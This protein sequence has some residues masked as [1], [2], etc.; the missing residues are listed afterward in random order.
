MKPSA[1]I[2]LLSLLVALCAAWVVE[3]NRRGQERIARALEAANA[4]ARADAEYQRRIADAERERVRQREAAE[5]AAKMRKM[6]L[7]AEMDA[8]RWR[9]EMDRV[10][11]EMER[12]ANKRT[13]APLGGPHAA[14]GADR[15]A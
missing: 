1:P 13:D 5:H 14:A 6:K 8:A 10:L 15:A 4:A 12:G 3:S 7:E 9:V 2:I 11:R